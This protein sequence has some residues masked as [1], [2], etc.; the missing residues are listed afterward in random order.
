MNNKEVILFLIFQKSQKKQNLILAFLFFYYVELK[1]MN[2]IIF[3]VCH[4]LIDYKIC[5]CY[6]MDL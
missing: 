2:E 4:K 5:Y 6:F 1:R 3:G